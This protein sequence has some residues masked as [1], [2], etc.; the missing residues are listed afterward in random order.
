MK[1]KVIF[2]FQWHKTSKNSQSLSIWREC[3]SMSRDSCFSY[4]RSYC[5]ASWL[6][7]SNSPWHSHR[8][9]RGTVSYYSIP[10][11]KHVSTY[12]ACF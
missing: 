5:S 9:S 12:F 6:G 2:L 10:Q 11:D 3:S 1:Q 7:S 4:Q 8:H